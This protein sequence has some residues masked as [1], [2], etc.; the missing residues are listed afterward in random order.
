MHKPDRETIIWLRETEARAFGTGARESLPKTVMSDFIAHATVLTELMADEYENYPEHFVDREYNREIWDALRLKSFAIIDYPLGV[1]E[2]LFRDSKKHLVQNLLAGIYPFS[3]INA[4]ATRTPSGEPAIFFSEWLF[5]FLWDYYGSTALHYLRGEYDKAMRK[6]LEF[7]EK[8]QTGKYHDWDFQRILE[9]PPS[10][11]L[12]RWYVLLSLVYIFAHE[13]GHV[14]L[15]HTDRAPLQIR[16]IELYEGRQDTLHVYSYNHVQEF[17]A[18]MFAS[19]VYF[20]LLNFGFRFEHDGF[21]RSAHIRGFS[22]LRIRA[23]LEEGMMIDDFKEKEHPPSVLRESYMLLR[24]RDKLDK[25]G[26]SIEGVER[27]VEQA[28]LQL[29]EYDYTKD[30]GTDNLIG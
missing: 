5:S 29:P 20:G 21:F 15:G 25:L 27:V 11:N 28:W 14:L 24:H 18:D 16:E 23:R 7:G 30:L 22:L 10:E 6:D 2:T 4:L 8:L 17:D 26:I 12:S 3:E 13:I 9:S 19:D 1:I